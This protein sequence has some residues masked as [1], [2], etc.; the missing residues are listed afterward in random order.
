[1]PAVVV[2][3]AG[4]KNLYEKVFSH[5]VSGVARAMANITAFIYLIIVYKDPIPNL[6]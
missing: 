2:V 3:V 1:L 6:I 4:Y 5:N